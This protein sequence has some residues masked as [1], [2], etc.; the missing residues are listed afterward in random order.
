MGQNVE[1]LSSP[2]F[3]PDTKLLVFLKNYIRK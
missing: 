3:N 2:S 1:D